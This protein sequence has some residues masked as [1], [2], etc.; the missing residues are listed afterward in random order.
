[1]M[2]KKHEWQS[3]LQ[4]DLHELRK[5][6]LNATKTKIFVVK[7]KEF[8]TSQKCKIKI[9]PLELKTEKKRPLSMLEVRT[10]ILRLKKTTTGFI[11]KHT[12]GSILLTHP[13]EVSHIRNTDC[14]IRRGQQLEYPLSVAFCIR[15]NEDPDIHLIKLHNQYKNKQMK[16]RRRMSLIF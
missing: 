4:C 13:H 9:D 6:I 16:I 11:E 1:M 8:S 3:F 12:I 15:A 10:I 14:G 5:C 2:E 7:W